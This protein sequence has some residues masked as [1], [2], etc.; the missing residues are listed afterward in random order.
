MTNPLTPVSRRAFLA[1]AASL[2]LA[3]L[4]ATRALG[5]ST[6]NVDVVIVGAG[7]AGIAA[8]RRVAAAGLSYALL[9]A[10]RRT[11]GRALTDAALF[12]RPVDLGA[13]RLYD[14]ATNPLV[15]LG[16]EAR[17]PLYAA[18]DAARLFVNGREARES[19]Y[20]DYVAA[21]RR[22]ERAIGAAGDAGRDLP[23]ARVMPDLAPWG[24][25]AAFILGPATC[26]KDL[27]QVS[28]V[29]FSRAEPRDPGAFVRTGVGTFISSLA[30]PLTVRT[31]TAATSLELGPR[32]VQVVTRKGTVTGR[33]A[34][35]AVPPSMMASGKLRVGN[36]PARYRAAIERITLGAYDHIIF[37]WPGNPLRLQ[38]DES[39]QVK[40]DS[41]R[42]FSLVA[43]LGGSDLHLMEVGGKLAAD[44]ADG[45]PNSGAAFLKEA[46]GRSF[47]SS[48]A[49]RV[50]KV[51]QT[52]WTKEPYALG[53]WS[54][55]LPG[56]GNLR[57]AFTEV[58]S[59][60]LAFAGEHAH[61]TLWGTLN[62]AWAS[63]ERAAAQ[64]IRALGGGNAALA[65]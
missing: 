62:G 2:P 25:S 65:Q 38:E 46:L 63:G 29:D 58:V 19:D 26:A 17:A 1:G 40:A 15:A 59:G 14:P 12:G 13:F 35:L 21:L 55:A 18:P 32:L 50:G 23:A 37:E 34:I 30:A 31:D 39:V 5:Q 36:L 61:E 22:G 53:A 56:A 33:F 9:E 43:R 45:P 54:C 20:E 48:L 16:T 64:A 24:Q 52:R 57:R 41:S 11:G 8:A 28:T 42:T 7:A 27:D 60:R 44:L 4:G 51:H 6:G 3:G 10:S 47:G 49:A